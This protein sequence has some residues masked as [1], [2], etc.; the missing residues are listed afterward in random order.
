V[1]QHEG[2]SLPELSGESGPAGA[3]GGTRIMSGSPLA[4]RFQ[5]LS[6]DSSPSTEQRKKVVAATYEGGASITETAEAH[7][8]SGGN[9]A[10]ARWTTP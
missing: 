5:A 7:H 8:A 1:G 4:Y 10:Y 3:G 9:T 2:K 6:S